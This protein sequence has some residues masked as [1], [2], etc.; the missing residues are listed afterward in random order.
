MSINE[1][2]EVEKRSEDSLYDIH[3]YLE[4]IFWRAYEWSAYLSKIFPSPLTDD[5]RLKPTIR[6]NKRNNKKIIQVGLQ[7]SS[8]Y[9]Y[10][11]NVIGNDEIF[12]MNERHIVIHCKELFNGYDFSNYE[13]VLDGWKYTIEESTKDNDITP[14][15]SDINTLISEIISYPIES[16]SLID[17]L[18]F[19]IHIKDIATKIKTLL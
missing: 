4:G 18:Q 15:K 1:I 8:F 5:E 17:N 9:K 3:F 2:I 10:F 11:P 13:E 12:E 16:K 6:T 7:L 14:N 19:L